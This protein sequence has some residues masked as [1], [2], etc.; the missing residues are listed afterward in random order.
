[1]SNDHNVLKWN[2][3]RYSLYT[4]HLLVGMLDDRDSSTPKLG[5]GR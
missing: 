3:A 5:A 1:M 4:L 2:H